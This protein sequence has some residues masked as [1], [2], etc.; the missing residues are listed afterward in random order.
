MLKASKK[1]THEL[2]CISQN[3]RVPNLSAPCRGQ[4]VPTQRKAAARLRQAHDE[5]AA[6]IVFLL[7]WKLR[8]IG[9]CQSYFGPRIA[10]GV[11]REE[12]RAANT[13]VSRDLSLSH[14][15]QGPQEF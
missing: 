4:D 14:P 13:E 1:I 11:W 9:K 5:R 8:V 2:C 6:K 3:A 7:R 10:R 15:G 12:C